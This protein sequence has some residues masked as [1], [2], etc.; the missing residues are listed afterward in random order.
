MNKDFWTSILDFAQTTT[1]QVGTQLLQDFG[2]VQASQKADGS[3]VTQSDKWADQVLREAIAT[4]FPEHGILSEEGDQTFPGSEWCWVIDPLDGTTNF[5]RGIPLW[6]I[7]LGLLYQGTPV[8]GCI[9]LPP[10][11]QVFHGFFP[12]ESQL[13]IPSGAFLNH[14]PIHSSNDAPGSNHFF[15][16]CARSTSVIQPGFPCKIR[17]LGV[18]SYNFLTVAAGTTLGAVEATP[19]VWDLAGAWVIV[20]AAGGA[21]V[22]LHSQPL[23]PLLPGKDYGDRS[24][25]TLVVSHAELVPVFRPYMQKIAQ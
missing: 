12:G 23:F 21:W 7:S 17:M 15:S 25:P 6:A 14:S 1:Q 24:F 3:L 13:K 4:H 19:K 2:H 10:L 5:T 18:A 11:N 16:L 22:S 9:Y 8:F 20:K